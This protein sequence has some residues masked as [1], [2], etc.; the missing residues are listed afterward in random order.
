MEN[1]KDD[2]TGWEKEVIS[3]IDKGELGGVLIFV[4]SLLTQQREKERAE[5]VQVLEHI[6]GG[7]NYDEL[8][9]DAIAV[10]SPTPKQEEEL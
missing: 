4:Q 3:L 1:W 9:R 7:P 6:Q 2:L 8:I 5:F 10:Y